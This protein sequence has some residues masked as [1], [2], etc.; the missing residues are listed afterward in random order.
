MRS[1]RPVTDPEALKPSR[2]V[3]G[4]L[5]P[6]GGCWGFRVGAGSYPLDE[7]L[8]GGDWNRFPGMDSALV[9]CHETH[10]RFLPRTRILEESEGQAALKEFCSVLLLRIVLLLLL[11]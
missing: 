1:L 4:L 3:W 9:C 8:E 10:D 6:L 11:R 5:G 7:L 2:P